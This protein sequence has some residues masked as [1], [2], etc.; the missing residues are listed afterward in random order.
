MLDLR[1]SA[2]TGMIPD[3]I[4]DEWFAAIDTAAARGEFLAALTIWVV[5]GRR[6]DISI[7][8]GQ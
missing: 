1:I 2:E 5:T 8:K 3:D 6:P 7:H 4:H